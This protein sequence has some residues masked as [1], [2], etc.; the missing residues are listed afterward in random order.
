MPDF[1]FAGLFAP[2]TLVLADE[3]GSLLPAAGATVTIENSSSDVP[4]FYTSRTKGSTTTPDLTTD[5]K[6]NW[7]PYYLDPGDGYTYTVVDAAGHSHGPYP[8]TVFP[9]PAESTVTFVDFTIE[10]I[11]GSIAS[12]TP[13]ENPNSQSV[14]VTVP[15]TYSPTGSAV[16]SLQ[17]ALSAT[18][19]GSA[20]TVDTSFPATAVAGQIVTHRFIVPPSWFLRLDVVHATIG[21]ATYQ[22][23]AA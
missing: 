5:S 11:V 3:S 15:I 7:G 20:G 13:W 17:V 22:N 23:I 18:T 2:G 19:E 10:T 12:G 1:T 9:D 4:T 8:F 16:A 6:G 14:V 21:A